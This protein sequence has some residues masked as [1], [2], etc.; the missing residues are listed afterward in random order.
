MADGETIR[1]FFDDAV[2]ECPGRVAIE[3]VVDGETRSRTVGE[4]GA[5]VREIAELLASVGI[6]PRGKP[7]ALMLENGPEWVETYL[8]LAGTAVSVVP[9]DP[10]LRP[11]EIVYIM[12]NASCRALI[13]DHS[14]VE[15][16]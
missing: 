5:R 13:T 15:V 2:R 4:M 8:A 16:A 1:T 3:F 6:E 10:K 7:V 14:H 12:R 11:A 9:L